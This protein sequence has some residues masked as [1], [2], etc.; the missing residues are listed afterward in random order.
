MCFPASSAAPWHT[1]SRI[2]SAICSP[3]C[4]T[5]V[6]GKSHRLPIPPSPPQVLTMATISSL[7][8]RT[9]WPSRPSARVTT[10]SPVWLRFTV[11]CS[12]PSVAASQCLNMTVPAANISQ[13]S[14]RP[15]TTV[16]RPSLR[17]MSTPMCATSSTTPP[18]P[19]SRWN[20]R[21][22]TC[23]F[24]SCRLIWSTPP[25]RN[26]SQTTT[27]LSPWC[28]PRKMASRSPPRRPCARW[29]RLSTP[30]IF[31]LLSTRSRMS[32]L[33]PTFPPPARLWPHR[34]FPSGALPSGPSPT[35]PPW[36]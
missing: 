16:R 36:L 5:T 26:L 33:S 10:S 27:A 28:F 12:A 22:S 14:R 2:I 3:P 20:T 31:P 35:A 32:P 15:T 6:L 29:W 4:S 24:P 19:V 7:T 11:S 17:A 21:P 18:L 25:S 1:G 13:G 30:R 23:S 8:Q 9:R 34:S